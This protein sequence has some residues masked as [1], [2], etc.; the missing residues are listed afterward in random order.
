VRI[1]ISPFQAH[2]HFDAA[3]SEGC[4]RTNRVGIPGLQGAV[5]G[6]QGIGVSVPIAAAVAAATVGFA[7]DLHIPKGRMLVIGA[8]SMMLAAGMVEAATIGTTTIK[9]EG[10]S[11]CVHFSVEP[12]LTC[13]PAI[14]QVSGT[15]GRGDAAGRQDR[16]YRSLA[17]D[18]NPLRVDCVLKTDRL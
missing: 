15:A 17:I 8:Q 1:V 11:P 4:P 6:T 12:L 16:D 5:T 7:W 18:C 13:L 2:L 10:A 3:S 9:V 14:F